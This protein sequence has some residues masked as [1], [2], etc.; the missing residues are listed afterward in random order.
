M[1]ITRLRDR[2]VLTESLTKR[3]RN[4][5]AVKDLSLEI[6]HGEI[7]GLIGSD[8]AGKTTTIQMLCSILAPSSGL[9]FVDGHD[10]EKEPDAIRAK[11]GYM[12]QDFT[13]YP[14]MTVNENIDFIADLRGV[15]RDEREHQKERLLRFSRMAPFRNQ[16]AATLSGGMKKKLALSCALIHRPKILILDEPTTAV[17]PLS[18]SELWK[19]LYE[20][21]V[22]GITVVISTPYMDEAER[23]GRVALMQE[24]EVIAC[25]TPAR[26]KELIRQKVCSLNPDKLHL[27]CKA[28]REELS[29]PGQVYGDRIRMFL[30]EPDT[31]IPKIR[32]HLEGKGIVVEDVGQVAPSMDDVFMNLLKAGEKNRAKDIRTSFHI[33][34]PGHTSIV[35]DELTKQF[36]DFTAVNR[37]SFEVPTGTVFGLLGP[38]GAGKTTIIKMLCGLLPPTSGKA[39]VAGYDISTGSRQVKNNIGYMAQLFSLYPDLT[40]SQNLDFYASVYGLGNKE[41][42]IKMDWALDLAGLKGKEKL[43]TREL[44]GGWKQKLAL[45]CAIMHQP[46]V[47]FLDEPTSGVDPVGR[48]EFWDAIQRFSEEGVTT[49]VTTH[50]MDEAERCNM[51]GLI[52]AGRLVALGT[53]HELKHNLPVNFYE[54]S[55][56]PILESYERLLLTD[57][58]SRAALFGDRIHIMTERTEAELTPAR[59][60]QAGVGI[61]AITQITPSLEDVFI[62]HIML[63]DRRDE[64]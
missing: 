58:I 38:N 10:V 19:I 27:A 48:A 34:Q 61:E 7:F 52:N 30:D 28:L 3:F 15:P 50:F 64:A 44:S 1:G 29:I 32:K 35:V 25:D 55:A 51:L 13:L 54:V 42:K 49:I 24:G 41:K 63:E 4:V 39:M 23:C 9:M 57:F 14:D 59:L 43:L 17:D 60:R 37:V 56:S 26:L 36:G 21:I 22:E 18:R 46:A 31:E 45:G 53:P 8:G 20:F 11:M 33:S 47:L 62:Y 16:R 6:R 2:A 12:S 5:S 40:V